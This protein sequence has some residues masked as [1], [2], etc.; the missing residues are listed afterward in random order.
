MAVVWNGILCG[1]VTTTTM[2]LRETL[3]QTVETTVT[4]NLFL[5]LTACQALCKLSQY[6][7][8]ESP[9]VTPDRVWVDLASRNIYLIT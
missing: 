4:P 3:L 2:I 9:T 6:F 8:G 5:E 7:S 1:S